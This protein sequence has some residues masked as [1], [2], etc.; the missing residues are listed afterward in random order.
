MLDCKC[1]QDEESSLIALPD[2]KERSPK[3]AVVVL[4]GLWIALILLLARFCDALP[5]LDGQIANG[6]RRKQ[7]SSMLLARSLTPA[8]VPDLHHLI[9]FVA[10][11]P[12]NATLKLL[13]YLNTSDPSHLRIET[14]SRA[15]NG[16]HGTQMQ[17]NDSSDDV[18]LG[19]VWHSSLVPFPVAGTTAKVSNDGILLATCV[20]D[21][22]AMAQ[23]AW[24]AGNAIEE[25]ET[26]CAQPF[27]STDAETGCVNIISGALAGFADIASFIADAASSCAKSLN[28]QAACATDISGIVQGFMTLF[29]GATGANLACRQGNQSDEILTSILA[30]RRLEEQPTARRFLSQNSSEVQANKLEKLKHG[31]KKK[32]QGWEKYDSV[33][34]HKLAILQNIQL[35]PEEKMQ[36]LQL[37]NHESAELASACGNSIM[38]LVLNFSFL[39]IF[40]TSSSEDC[41]PAIISRDGQQ[42]KVSC[43][44]DIL[45]VI[46]AISD[47]A[48]HLTNTV[49]T[50]PEILH[51]HAVCAASIIDLV[52]AAAT[53]TASFVSVQTTCGQI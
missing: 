6:L 33:H 22:F 51:D 3:C 48:S 7:R 17:L 40:F 15:W 1:D 52:T 49:V 25:A 41:P 37:E 35:S 5:W 50:C 45:S 53:I 29:D 23:A 44:L 34:K 43:A 38:A 28:V 8:S 9:E 36:A 19:A 42:A 31:L 24:D 12:G 32:I 47:I 16:H 4:L 18:L 26:A 46:S 27:E 30:S 21:T 13:K 2:A 11:S 10:Q 39:G 14:T 20:L